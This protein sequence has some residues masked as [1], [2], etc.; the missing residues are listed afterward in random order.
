MGA[1]QET[2]EAGRKGEAREQVVEVGEDSKG[3]HGEGRRGGL[4]GQGWRRQCSSK[5]AG[6]GKGKE[7]GEN[8]GAGTWGSVRVER[9]EGRGWLRNEGVQELSG[10]QRE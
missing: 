1:G 5:E 4:Q 8:A 9:Q 10:G 3:L 6:M 7:K 2:C